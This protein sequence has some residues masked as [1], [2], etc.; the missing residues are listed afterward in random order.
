M[1]SRRVVAVLALAALVFTSG[2]IGFLTGE[3]TLTFESEPAAA[4]AT[5]AAN[6]GYETNGTETFAVNRTLSF[7]GQERK[8]AA[9]NHITTYEKTLD[10]GFFGEARLGSFSVI[11]TPAVEVAGQPR[12]PIG[13]YSND[14]LIRLVDNRY[15]GLSDVDPV[16]S[17][18]VQMLGQTTNV[19]KYSATARFGG[20]EVDVYV[21][22]TKVRH[23]EDF[24]VAMGLYPQ[25]LDGEEENV[26]ELIRSVEHPSEA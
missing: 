10:L 23:N 15:Q 4:D 12:S 16:S 18:N 17:R 24:I 3:E 2:C 13:D 20:D 25:Q 14:D 11:S 19:T 5:V 6:A 21:H 22:V 8:I 1:S 9:S 26:L 7:G